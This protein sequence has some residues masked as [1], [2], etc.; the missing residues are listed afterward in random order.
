[1]VSNALVH[2]INGEDWRL[3]NLA[4]T[5]QSP[6]RSLAR[7]AHQRAVREEHALRLHNQPTRGSWSTSHRDSYDRGT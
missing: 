7:L 2:S 5:E 6:W 3:A 4:Q 1:M